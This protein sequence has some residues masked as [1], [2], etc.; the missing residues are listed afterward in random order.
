MRGERQHAIEL[1]GLYHVTR[2]ELN[3]PAYVQDLTA[4]TRRVSQGSVNFSDDPP[5]MLCSGTDGSGAS[6]GAS[7]ACRRIATMSWDICLWPL[8]RRNE[9][10][11]ILA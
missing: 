4:A 5:L 7:V 6:G 2:W 11:A 3:N 9:H 8:T 1:D 10:C